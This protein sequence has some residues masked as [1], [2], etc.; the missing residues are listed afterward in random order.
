M[1][2]GHAQNVSY[3]LIFQSSMNILNGQKRAPKILQLLL[4]TLDYIVTI[5]DPHCTFSI[6]R[7]WTN[8]LNL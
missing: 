4:P 1:I 8:H 6:L 3:Q 5:W 2:L 7:P